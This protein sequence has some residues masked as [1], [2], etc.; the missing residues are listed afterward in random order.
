MEAMIPSLPPPLLHVRPIIHMCSFRASLSFIDG[1]SY[2]YLSL[3]VHHCLRM[4]F[5]FVVSLPPF[6][7][8][9]WF[10]ATKCQTLWQHKR[11]LKSSL[12]TLC[13]NITMTDYN[14]ALSIKPEMALVAMSR[15]REN[16]KWI[17]DNGDLQMK[18]SMTD[19]F[20]IVWRLGLGSLAWR[21][22]SQS[23]TEASFSLLFPF[24]VLDFFFVSLDCGWS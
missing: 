8:H 14:L 5:A 16:L 12:G 1:R 23:T 10:S 18:A 15:V 21:Q 9:F 20:P 7:S 4:P 24:H 19:V 6:D 2:P 22:K 13:F 3:T 11:S 17:R